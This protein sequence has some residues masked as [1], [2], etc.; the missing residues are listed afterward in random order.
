MSGIKNYTI[1]KGATFN[2]SVTYQDSNAVAIDLTGFTATMVIYDE[3]D[4]NIIET[5]TG[6]LPTPTN[7]TIILTITDEDTATYN[8][9]TGVYKLDIESGGGIVTRLLTGKMSIIN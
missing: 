3:W 4:G 7:G 8:V 1:H 9:S 2:E 5:V 6:S